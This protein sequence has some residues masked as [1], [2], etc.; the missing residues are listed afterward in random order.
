[1]ATKKINDLTVA[2]SVG[3]TMQLETDTGGATANKITALQIKDYTR[4]AEEKI[5]YVA[6][7]GDDAN[8]GT[9]IQEAF[10]T[11]QKGIDMAEAEQA[12]SAPYVVYKQDAQ[13]IVDTNLVVSQG[14]I[15]I[16]A[17]YSVFSVNYTGSVIDIT[18]GSGKE[19]F[20]DFDTLKNASATATDRVLRIDVG[21]GSVVHVNVDHLES[22][23]CP[24]M[25]ITGSGE[26]YL[27]CEEIINP[28]IGDEA[29]ICSGSVTVY[30]IND[31]FQGSID[32]GISTTVY[33]NGNERNVPGAGTGD[34]ING[35]ANF[36]Y[37]FA[38]EGGMQIAGYINKGFPTSSA[39]ARSFSD[40]L[41]L[42]YYARYDIGDDKLKSTSS[43]GSFNIY[44]ESNELKLGA[45]IIT[46]GSELGSWLHSIVIQPDSVCNL[47]YP[48]VKNT[49]VVATTGI[50]IDKDDM[51]HTIAYNNATTD[52]EITFDSDSTIPIGAYGY[53]MQ[54]NTN[55]VKFIAG[56]AQTIKAI[57]TVATNVYTDGNGAV[58]KWYKYGANAWILSGDV[59][60]V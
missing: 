11:V 3:D 56:G 1:M 36:Y 19:S 52:L 48:K 9:N 53:V 44:G 14:N 57:G 12:A 20:F 54:I 16:E 24:V 49:I 47:I 55:A 41:N 35:L 51:N 58:V 21:S 50:T 26:V 43:S 23:G 38:N 32:A 2:G 10:E 42:A 27:K 17:P 4:V 18:V 40:P 7:H 8:T 25:E 5:F 15:N 46:A 45:Q 28:S 13:H 59:V 31:E 33:I 22:G 34:L 29:L 39:E 30:I 37:R 60:W 6:G